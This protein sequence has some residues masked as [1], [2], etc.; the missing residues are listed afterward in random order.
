MRR[1]LA[2]VSVRGSGYLDELLQ[3]ID[4]DSLPGESIIS[5]SLCIL[6]FRLF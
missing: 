4:H 5:L 6:V 2:K 3:E 1:T